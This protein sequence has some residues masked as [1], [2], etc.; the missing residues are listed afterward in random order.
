MGKVKRFIITK[1]KLQLKS[2]TIMR[3]I[4][5]ETLSKIRSKVRGLLYGIMEISMKVNGI[6]ARGKDLGIFIIITATSMRVI[7]KKINDMVKVNIIGITF[8]E[9]KKVSRGRIFIMV[10]M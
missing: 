9:M 5:K 2:I 4:T 6:I 3:V 7:S 10:I 8:I 1:V